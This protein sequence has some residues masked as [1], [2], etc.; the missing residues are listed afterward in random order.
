MIALCACGCDANP[1]GAQGHTAFSP[2]S[3]HPARTAPVAAAGLPAAST[4]GLGQTLRGAAD[5]VPRILRREWLR[6]RCGGLDGWG[7]V[8]LCVLVVRDSD[9]SFTG[10]PWLMHVGELILGLNTPNHFLYVLHP[11]GID[12]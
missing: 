7:K 10:L 9:P 3:S 1:D 6:C 4:R 12:S 5:A 8:F 11:T 2:A